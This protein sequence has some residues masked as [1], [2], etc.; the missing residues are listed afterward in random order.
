MK[1]VLVFLVLCALAYGA[2]FSFSQPEE[3]AK[4]EQEAPIQD[5]LTISVKNELKETF[6]DSV[7]GIGDSITHKKSL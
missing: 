1:K 4:T 2:W 3:P 5:T 7:N 6:C